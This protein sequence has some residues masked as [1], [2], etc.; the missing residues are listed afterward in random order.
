MSDI[1]L[2]HG[3]CHGAWAWDLV[4]P[5]LQALGHRAR[6]I[7]L[8]GRRGAASLAEQVEAVV[9]ALEGPT[10][11]VGHSAAGFAITA[12]AEA[13]ALVAG[14]VYVCAYVP[15]AG[16]SLAQMRRAGPSQPLAG[17]F[18]VDRARGVFGFDPARAAELFFH[19]CTDADLAVARLCVQALA[20]M[21]TA[22]ASV[23]R[24]ETLPRAYIRCDADRAIPPGYQDD[25]AGGIAR[26]A[27]LPCGHSPFLAMP[28]PLAAQIDRLVRAS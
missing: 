27:A 6:A 5:P 22:L 14:L 7:D 9:A 12:A 11:L 1:L 18:Q 23:A 20:P 10:V 2:L 28:E 8:P 19:D 17:A 3:A 13:S 4:I 24:A 26:M 25:M 15:V 21:E 16:Q